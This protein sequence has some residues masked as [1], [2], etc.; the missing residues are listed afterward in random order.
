MRYV[1]SVFYCILYKPMVY[2]YIY[3]Y[4]STMTWNTLLCWLL[5]SPWEIIS[6]SYMAYRCIYYPQCLLKHGHRSTYALLAHITDVLVHH[7][8]R[9]IYALARISLRQFYHVLSIGQTN[10]CPGPWLP[11]QL[12]TRELHAPPLSKCFLPQSPSALGTLKSLSW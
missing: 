6:K 2:I 12:P 1:L 3:I 7:C 8:S 5:K 9:A 4:I 10:H 11:T